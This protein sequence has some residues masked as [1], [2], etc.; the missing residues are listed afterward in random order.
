[1]AIVDGID[2]TFLGAT[3]LDATLL[4]TDGGRLT[5]AGRHRASRSCSEHPAVGAPRKVLDPIG[6]FARG[7][8]DGNL[9]ICGTA[10]PPFDGRAGRPS[11]PLVAARLF[12]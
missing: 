8:V 6:R 2:V 3:I 1:M 9:G 7:T 4:A 10:Q 5:V 11:I 12:V